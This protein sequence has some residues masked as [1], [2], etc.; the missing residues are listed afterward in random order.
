MM[1]FL[2]M[3][4]ARS[5]KRVLVNIG[6]FLLLGIALVAW[7]AIDILR[8]DFIN[9]PFRITAA[10]ETSPGLRPGFQVAY[11]G[12]KTGNVERVELGDGE[13]VATLRIDREADLPK[14]IGAAVRRQSAVGE[15]FVDL[16]PPP[17]GLAQT[18]R[19]ADGDHIPI[20][21]TETPVTYSELFRVLDDLVLALD[22]DALADLFSDLAEGLEGRGGSIRQLLEGGARFTSSLSDNADL[23]D[24]VIDDLT[25]LTGT[26][27][28]TSEAIGQGWDNLAALAESLRQST[29][30]IAGT[31]EEGPKL[32]ELVADILVA[33]E[34]NL[35]CMMA[36]GGTVADRLGQDDTIS[37]LADL[38]SMAPEAAEVV[39]QISTVM[40]DGR[41]FV[42]LMILSNAGLGTEPVAV[43][44]EPLT[45]PIP[46]PIPECQAVP[47]QHPHGEG[48][49]TIPGGTSLP[50]ETPSPVEV[51]ERPEAVE[52]IPESSAMPVGRDFPFLA[53]IAGLAVVA[54]ALTA[55]WGSSRLSAVRRRSGG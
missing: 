25:R 32:A 50:Q 21:L 43:Y 34:G 52:V 31:L 38:L 42:R 4:T 22:P 11:L 29:Q 5:E 9:R 53:L 30:D 12:V 49:S 15:P 3:L 46:R 54:A 33:S 17:E 55:A 20:E 47:R 44:P 7:A 23:V 1:R 51:G 36:S 16:I 40:P 26:L 13:A 24:A 35:S 18:S 45:L 48:A 41:I 39:P 19:L 37:A 8:P 2:R 6:V 14:N 10:F 28:S 27:A